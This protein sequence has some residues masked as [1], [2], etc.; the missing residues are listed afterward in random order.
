MPGSVIP[1]S[2]YD[3]IF[4]ARR[5]LAEALK[6][7]EDATLA[8]NQDGEEPPVQVLA[9]RVVLR[10]LHDLA[11]TAH[12]AVSDLHN[13][14]IPLMFTR[15]APQVH[16][17]VLG[18]DVSKT[19]T[20]GKRVMYNGNFVGWIIKDESWLKYNLELRPNHRTPWPE[21]GMQLAETEDESLALLRHHQETAS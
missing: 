20:K 5:Q 16:D 10:N 9:Q 8:Y 14:T 18:D 1:Q 4:H 2:T 15:H 12:S 19:R 21:G 7:I 11:S 3:K 17:V 6:D 13:C